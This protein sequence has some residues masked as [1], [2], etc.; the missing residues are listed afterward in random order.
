MRAFPVVFA[1]LL[2]LSGVGNA[3]VVGATPDAVADATTEPPSVEGAAATVTATDSA[4][5]SVTAADSA[6]PA[7][8]VNSTN[9]TDVPNVSRI[10]ALPRPAVDVSSIS[11]VTVDAAGATDTGTEVAETRM[12]T[13]YVE[14]RLNRTETPA[15]RAAVIRDSLRTLQNESDGLRLRQRAAISAYNNGQIDA[16]T[17]VLRL[18]RI[19]TR[20]ELLQN[21]ANLLGTL[22]RESFDPDDPIFTNLTRVRSELDAFDG[23]VRERVAAAVQGDTAGTRVFVAT[24]EKGVVLTSI[25][26]G[27]YVRESYRGFLWEQ[28][29]PGITGS[30]VANVTARS[31]PEIWAARNGT[32]GFGSNTT[33]SYTVQHTGGTLD[34][35]IR[36]ENKRVYREVQRIPLEQYP[37]RPV[38]TKRL[39]GLI[40]LVNRTYAGGPLRVKVID[41]Q[42]REPVNVTVSVSRIGASNSGRIGRTGDD[43]VLWTL[44]PGGET[45]SYV[46]TALDI[47]SAD[48]RV[49][50]LSTSTTAPVTVGS[51]LSGSV[52]PPDDYRPS[53]VVRADESGEGS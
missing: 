47:D 49:V 24:T 25:L 36:G 40:L 34:I 35:Q 44:S 48:N 18:A 30:D 12:Q 29:G 20:A 5:A 10:L 46:I 15:A 16:Q 7:G 51:A 13:M 31:Y 42:T 32:S 9:S 38:T 26:D 33:F 4:A 27:S 6:T 39:M 23:P 45:Q 52:T 1:A 3:A 21:R 28:G 50:Q 53:V 14:E 8:D 2:V 43:G 19:D 41:A 17:F 11:V 37:L 22:V